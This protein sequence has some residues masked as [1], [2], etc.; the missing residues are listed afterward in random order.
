MNKKSS[1]PFPHNPL[2]AHKL[3]MLGFEKQNS[4]SFDFFSLLPSDNIDLLFVSP[5]MYEEYCKGWHPTEEQM[6]SHT[7]M[8]DL[9]YK[10]T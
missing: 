2:L 3:T 6:N 1:I 10:G 7:F 9:F 5:E 4:D 8:D